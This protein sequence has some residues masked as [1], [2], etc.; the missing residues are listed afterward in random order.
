M[1]ATTDAPALEA[2]SL[3]VRFGGV[4]A[5]QDVSIAIPPNQIT[6]VIGPNGAGKTTFFNAVC[7]FVKPQSGEISYGGRPLTGVNP[8][9]LTELGIS[10]TLQ[11]LG[12]WRGLTV[13]E[14]VMAGARRQGRP[15]F[16]WALLG[17]PRADHDETRV[18]E[19]ATVVLKEL[20]IDRYANAY[21]AALPFGVQ[22]WVALARALASEPSLLLLDEPASGLTEGEIKE[23]TERLR[24]WRERMTIAL[25]EHRLDLVMSASD[26]VTVLDFGQVIAAGTPAEVQANPA[27]VAAYLGEE[28]DV[29]DA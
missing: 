22:K 14:N 10:R 16:A 15:G 7:G 21:P 4:V 13:V 3:T 2:R 20:G 27:V 5:L 11:G 19:A 24:G 6:A 28:L 1:A 12:L 25:V 23:L 9:Q 17:L 26:R 8:H 18:R 29:A